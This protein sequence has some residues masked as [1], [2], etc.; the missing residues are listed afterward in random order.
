MLLLLFGSAVRFWDVVFS[1]GIIFNAVRTRLS[2]HQKG[3]DIVSS[4]SAFNTGP[5][6]DGVGCYDDLSDEGSGYDVDCI[7]FMVVRYGTQGVS[8]RASSQSVE[9]NLPLCTMDK[10]VCEYDDQTGGLANC[11]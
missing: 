3:G 8:F 5:D 11:I 1:W 2:L 4:K 7:G 10:N 9:L 6:G